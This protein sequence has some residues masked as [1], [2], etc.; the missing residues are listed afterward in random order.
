[1]LSPGGQKLQDNIKPRRPGVAEYEGQEARSC[2]ILCPGGQELQDIKPRR[3]GAAK[4]L[5]PG[6]Q[7]LQDI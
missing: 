7:E 2:R 4:I 1:M 3:P 6:G 5:S